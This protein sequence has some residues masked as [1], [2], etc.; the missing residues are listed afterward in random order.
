MSLRQ[1]SAENPLLQEEILDYV[2]Q[3]TDDM[4]WVQK[5][6]IPVKLTK[7][8]SRTEVNTVVVARDGR[9]IHETS[10]IAQTGEGVDTRLCVDGSKDQYVKKPHKVKSGYRIDDGRT[11][12]NMHL[13]ETTDAHTVSDDI[14]QAFVAEKDLYLMSAWGKV[15]F[16]ARGGIVTI[17]GQEAIGNNNPCDMVVYTQQGLG[18]KVLTESAAVI[19][20]DVLR[21]KLPVTSGLKKFLK[22]AAEEDNKA[23]LNRNKGKSLKAMVQQRVLKMKLRLLAWKEKT[24]TLFALQRIDR[25][26]EHKKQKRVKTT[27]NNER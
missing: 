6:N 26:L 1:S 2:R 21:L 16:V 27:K 20:R 18:K 25:R 22:V 10:N 15:Q 3:N 13:A 5:I 9:K 23:I 7:V 11:F 4:F 12:D 24:L 17:S 8:D 19:K 14:R